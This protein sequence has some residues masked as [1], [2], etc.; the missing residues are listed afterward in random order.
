MILVHLTLTSPY[1]IF[2]K[3]GDDVDVGQ[4]VRSVTFLRQISK[5]CLLTRH[6]IHSELN[7]CAVRAST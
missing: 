5:L 1:L 7:A 6:S 2:D 3:L 4:S